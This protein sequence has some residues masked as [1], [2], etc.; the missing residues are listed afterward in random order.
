RHLPWLRGPDAALAALAQQLRTSAQELESVGIDLP[1][2]EELLVDELV[3]AESS[4][5]P[6][7]RN[8]LGGQTF[9]RV[10]ERVSA[11]E[12]TDVD[13]AAISNALA[14]AVRSDQAVV[15]HQWVTAAYRL[16]AAAVDG[17]PTVI[18]LEA[19]ALD[20]ADITQ[21]RRAEDA[22]SATHD[23]ERDNLFSDVDD[24]ANDD[25]RIGA[26]ADDPWLRLD[27]MVGL[28]GVKSTVRRALRGA[29]LAQRR[30]D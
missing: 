5:S 20:L 30:R 23:D 17:H 21:A 1:G 4:V 9:M 3:Q 29:E 7:I 27:R 11:D 6:V 16:L 15:A 18:D 26:P 22:G 24:S 12:A 13:R 8:A 14:R 25:D 28:S 2:L 19:F 10:R